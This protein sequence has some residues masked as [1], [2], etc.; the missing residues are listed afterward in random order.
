MKKKLLS[1]LL[2]G[3]L[4]LGLTACGSSTTSASS[5][6]PTSSVAVP[7]DL[8]VAQ[9]SAVTSLDPHVISD[10][11]SEIVVENMYN[12][13]LSYT[14]TYGEI[15]PSLCKS[16]DISED[17]TVYTLHLVS[18]VTFHNGDP[19][20]AQD[21]VY[22]LN[23]IVEK[24]TRASQFS[25]MTDCT[26]LDDQTVK[27]TLSEPFAPFL[28]YL[29]N[30][31]NAIVDKNVV[32]ANNGSLANV[33]A[34]TGPFMLDSWDNGS[35]VKLDKFSN[36]W[37]AGLPK[38]ENVTFRTISDETACSTAI[39]NGE[40]DIV[41][42]ATSTETAVLKNAAG[43]NVTSIPGTFWEYLGMNCKSGPLA[44]VK[45]RQAIAYAIDRQAINT[46]VKQG[47]A[48]VLT[49]ACIPSSHEAGLTTDTYAA[50]DLDKAK[51]LLSE[52]GYGNGDISLTIQAGSDWQ[53][54]VDAATMIKQQ[55][56]QIGINCEV[57]ALD[58]GVF[59]DN[60]NSGNFD[61]C[62]CGWSGFVD[63][64]EYLYDIF[65]TSGAYNQQNYSNPEF[66][67]LVEKARVTTDEDTRNDLYRQAQQILADDAPMAFLYMNNYTVAVRDGVT[68]FEPM[69][70]GDTLY[71]KNTTK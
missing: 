57:Q 48:T 8:T 52:A 36:Y 13:L 56:A 44:N 20:T 12:S 47:T 3:M 21:V 9:Q 19:M 11:A 29:A 23:R 2:T 18:G 34:G 65:T 41:L 16:Y 1:L 40:V 31:M 43:V 24:E 62:V 15:V 60:L 38:A 58:S 25:L 63:A 27:I 37:E 59:F 28:S 51:S 42:D 22:S 54:Q 64:D 39:R 35:S 53:Y 6:E 67:T 70:T 10:A 55:L 66:D 69:A 14:S 49:N 50:Q 45:V 68:G 71:L 61:M 26:A 7:C 30:P 46:A 32:E 4:L 17:G 33:D 5:S